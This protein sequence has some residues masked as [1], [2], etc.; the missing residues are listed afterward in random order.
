MIQLLD[1]INIVMV[2]NFISLSVLKFIVEVMLPQECVAQENVSFYI[3]VMCTCIVI[4]FYPTA[5]SIALTI[6]GAKALVDDL[7]FNMSL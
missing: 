6:S 5:A 2:H 7:W 4:T 3:K 1:N